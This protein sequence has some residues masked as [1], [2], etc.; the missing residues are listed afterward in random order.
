MSDV[1]RSRTVGSLGAALLAGLFSGLFYGTAV[2]GFVFLVPVQI[3]Y[4]RRGQKAGS[5]AAAAAFVFAVAVQLVQVRMA[6]GFDSAIVGAIT[7]LKF[8]ELAALPPALLLGALA[9]MNAGFWRPGT[10][11]ARG[12]AGTALA[13]LVATPAI[14]ALSRNQAF[15][16]QCESEIGSMLGRFAA[17]TGS[18]GAG[19]TLVSA[20]DVKAVMQASLVV[21]QSSYVSLLFVLMGGSWWMGNR[22]SGAGS[23][24]RKIASPLA[25]YRLPYICVW[26]FLAAWSAVLVVTYFRIGA[27]WS[28]I[29]WNLAI[30]ISLAYAVQGIGIA[31]H[32]M[33]RWNLP[34]MFRICIIVTAIILFCSPP[35]GTAFI[36]V[37]PLLGVTEVWIPYRNPKGVGA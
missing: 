5:L 32:L 14:I 26:P 25:E 7:P 6:G 27:P 13:A 20:M 35:F 24:G 19:E 9:L 17:Q 16:A 30:L 37:L 28:P 31:S 15:L 4:G 11:W 22:L 33:R 29:A 36:A 34:R 12:F 21:L 23:P 8:L 10:D 2:L 18:G 3:L 1:A